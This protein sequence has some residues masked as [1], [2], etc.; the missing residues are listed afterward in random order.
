MFL[1]RRKHASPV[2]NLDLKHG[3]MVVM[4]GKDL[5]KIDQSNLKCHE[6]YE[7][8]EKRRQNA[9]PVLNIYQKLY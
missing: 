7:D 4:H 9:P 8:S 5:Q 1:G 6:Q 3:D 2:L